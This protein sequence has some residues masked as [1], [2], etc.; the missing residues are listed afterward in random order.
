MIKQV[1]MKN[2]R[3]LTCLDKHLLYQI[4]NGFYLQQVLSEQD[5]CP[6]GLHVHLLHSSPAGT[7]SP[8]LT[9]IVLYLQTLI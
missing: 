9:F 2:V 3:K 6:S 4:L 8:I 7:L 5:N 1:I